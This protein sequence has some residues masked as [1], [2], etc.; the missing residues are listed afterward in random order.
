MNPSTTSLHNLARG[1]VGFSLLLAVLLAA[2]ISS[3]APAD[4]PPPPA[5][6]EETHR[7]SPSPE[8][9]P[10]TRDQGPRPGNQDQHAA[11]P[12]HG[13]HEHPLPNLFWAWP[14]VAL[15]LCIAILPLVPRTHHWW[16]ENSSKLIVALALAVVTLLYYQ[17]RGFGFHAPPGFKTVLQVLDHAVIVDYIPFIVL[18]FSLFTISGGISL[19]G[20][21]PAHPGTNTLILAVGGALASFIG[22]TGA[23]MLLIR[24]LLQ[25]NSERRRLVHTVIFF[26]F[27]VSNCGGLLLPIGDPPLFLGYLRG[28][29]F[30]WTF[31]LLPQWCLCLGILLA[32]YF[33]LDTWA[34]KHEAKKDLLWDDAVRQPLQLRGKINFLLLLGVV[35]SVGLLV[36][37]KTLPL[38]GWVVPTQLPLIKGLVSLREI[39]MLLLA[40]VSMLI[41]P[42][43]IRQD[44]KFNFFAIKEVACLFIGIFITMQVPIEILNAKGASLGIDSPMK[45]FWSTGVL[46]SFLDNAPTYVVFFETAKTLVH[47]SGPGVMDLPHDAFINLKHLMA[48]SCG[49]VFM[50][51]NTYIGNGPNLMVKAI[52]QQAGVKMPSFFGYMLYSGVIL[53]PIFIVVSL[54]FMH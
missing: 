21:I 19:R 40:G 1:R 22:T 36:P 32:L 10:H 45:F 3:P 13:Q 49:A 15:L 39:V 31:C 43:V 25:I 20:D 17:F 23:S 54:V 9:A 33:T 26:I 41:T 2:C 6:G 16:E 8:D 14:F 11:H 51:A 12:E 24:P 28:V 37:G 4:Q 30:L 29:P 42:R 44:N 47:Q 7:T 27:V 48:I 50:G 52:A 34:W 53:V 35:L 46:S 5:A 38:L 18:L